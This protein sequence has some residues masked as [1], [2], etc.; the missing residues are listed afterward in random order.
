MVER[1]ACPRALR[2]TAPWQV[3]L[4]ETGNK[5]RA[6][7]FEAGAIIAA[8]TVKGKAGPIA[9]PQGNSTHS[10]TDSMA[11]LI[12]FNKPYNVLCQ[13][14][15]TENRATLADFLSTPEC[16]GCYPAGRLD[17][18]SEG[19][20]LLTDDG[21]LQQQI[22]HPRH[23]LPKTYWVEV[24]GEPSAEAIAKL[25]QGVELKD[26]KTQPA[27][28]E[29]I[30]IPDL[31]PRVPPVRFRAQIPTHW[32]SITITE[33]RNRQVRR[34]TATVGLPTLRLVRA[35]IGDWTLGDLMPGAWRMETVATPVLNK[36]TSTSANPRNGHS[37]HRKSSYSKSV[38]K[39]THGKTAAT[40]P[41][42]K[43]A[44]KTVK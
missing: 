4:A 33:G 8:F 16:K 12:I 10:N 28:V 40:K 42:R 25:R 34:M 36:G 39:P 35:R 11:K 26:G 20:L 32:L 3:K 2:E 7:A 29:P 24:E 15:D 13:F 6:E 18:D 1:L 17:R 14:T 38:H 27:Q 19:L 9:T 23:K 44:R 37:K 21:K 31:W 22:S 41:A 30:G 5:L 43:R